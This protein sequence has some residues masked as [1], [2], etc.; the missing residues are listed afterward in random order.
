MSVALVSIAVP[1]LPRGDGEGKAKHELLCRESSN[2]SILVARSHG[3]LQEQW[4]GAKRRV[5]D[6]LLTW[7]ESNLEL[8][9]RVEMI[10]DSGDC[11]FADNVVTQCG[12]EL[13]KANLTLNGHAGSWLWVRKTG[14]DFSV[15]RWTQQSLEPL[16]WDTF[17]QFIL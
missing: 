10:P 3:S 8:C 12:A 15:R 7:V 14:R 2:L 5:V 9:I 1:T 6:S 13:W 11:G 16:N 4:G 17:L